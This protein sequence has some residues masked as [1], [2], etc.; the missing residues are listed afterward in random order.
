MLGEALL[1]SELKGMECFRR[2]RIHSS[3]GP[4]PEDCV[5]AG[6]LVEKQARI[7]RHGFLSLIAA[8]RTGNEGLHHHR[9]KE[10]WSA[11]RSLIAED[12]SI[13]PSVFETI[14]VICRPSMKL[15]QALRA[16]TKVEDAACVLCANGMC[17]RASR[18]LAG[19]AWAHE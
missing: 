10:R 11:T 9:G 8:V 7:R 6:T 17:L 2:S 19:S 14:D 4:G 16:S 15:L 3:H 5:T 13:L 1:G 12:A 18:S